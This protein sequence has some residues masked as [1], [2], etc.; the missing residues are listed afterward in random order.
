MPIFGYAAIAAL[1]LGA[2][3]LVPAVTLKG[4]GLAPRTRRVV[5]DTLGSRYHRT[6]ADQ[7]EFV[8]FAQEQNLGFDFTSPPKRP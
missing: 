3:L 7:W 5:L 8:H 2:V 6:F 1:L 4:L